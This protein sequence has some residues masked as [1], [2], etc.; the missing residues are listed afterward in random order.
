MSD[1]YKDMLLP[2]SYHRVKR[3]VLLY[4]AVLI[5]LYF[6]VPSGDPIAPWLNIHLPLRATAGLA[7]AATAYYGVVFFFEWRLARLLNSNV[8]RNVGA[9]MLSQRL[10]KM[11]GDFVSLIDRLA[12]S[13]DRYVETLDAKDLILRLGD[14]ERELHLKAHPIMAAGLIETSYRAMEGRSEDLLK[15]LRESKAAVDDAQAKVCASVENIGLNVESIA[16]NVR[17]MHSDMSK[18][19]Q[20]VARDRAITFYWLDAAVVTVMSGFATFSTVAIIWG[21]QIH[22][23]PPT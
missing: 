19:S 18:L 1:D 4:S 21:V 9:E 5:V 11:D 8:A 22:C 23:L 12:H 7:W 14:A 17:S 3:T 15:A 6:A 20:V 13:R 10:S 2:D 16:K